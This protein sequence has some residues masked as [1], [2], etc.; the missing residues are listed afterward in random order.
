M[1]S[2][3]RLIYLDW[4][5]LDLCGIEEGM[6]NSMKSYLAKAKGAGSAGYGSGHWLYQRLTGLFLALSTIWL[7]IFVHDIVASPGL[8]SILSNIVMLSLFMIAAFY[9]SYLGMQV[10]IED[11]IHCR[12]IRL[13]LIIFLQFFS[14][15]T[16]T[17]FIVAVIYIMTL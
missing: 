16:V 7:I 4:F 6:K 13:G 15:I 17:A 14:I 11:Y 5:I 10:I 9:H 8:S 1:D 12:A 2:G 3:Y